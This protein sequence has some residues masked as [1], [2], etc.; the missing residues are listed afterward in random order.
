MKKIQTQIQHFSGPQTYVPNA[1]TSFFETSKLWTIIIL[2]LVGIECRRAKIE[3]SQAIRTIRALP[4]PS[5][6]RLEP[7]LC[8]FV[9]IFIYWT[10]F[11]FVGT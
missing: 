11:P 6:T 1:M 5:S 3:P 2:A 9:Y 4:S 8:A 10:K 7:P